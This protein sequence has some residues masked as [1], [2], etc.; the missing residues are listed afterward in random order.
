MNHLPSFQTA[1]LRLRPIALHDAPALLEMSATRPP[2]QWIGYNALADMEAAE[3][4]VEWM[5]MIGRKAIPDICWAVERLETPGLIGL[6]QFKQWDPVERVALLGYELAQAHQGR[7]FMTEAVQALVWGC[8]QGFGLRHLDAHV[9]PDNAPSLRLL[10][11]LGFIEQCVLPGEGQ[12]DGETHDMLLFR[13]FAEAAQPAAEAPAAVAA[14][15]RDGR[16]GRR[17]PTR[18]GRAARS[19]APAP[20]HAGA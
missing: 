2:R 3:I 6:C 11:R 17:S 8:F 1:R 13:R 4:F 20:S 14:P 10:H 5:M 15:T 7:G 16:D 9:H 19:G 12:W 18:R